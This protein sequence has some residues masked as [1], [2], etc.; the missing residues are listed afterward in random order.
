MHQPSVIF[1]FASN[2][3][4]ILICFYVNYAKTILPPYFDWSPDINPIIENLRI[5]GI[6]NNTSIRDGGPKKACPER[7]PVW[8]NRQSMDAILQTA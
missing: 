6:Q 2:I 3:I 5:V 7:G 1:G 4:P 8:Q